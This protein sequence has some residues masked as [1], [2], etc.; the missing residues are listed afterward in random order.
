MHWRR[1]RGRSG[2]Q[3]LVAAAATSGRVPGLS[4]RPTFRGRGR[5]GVDRRGGD[6]DRVRLPRSRCCRRRSSPSVRAGRQRWRARRG[7]AGRRRWTVGWSCGMRRWL[8]LVVLRAAIAACRAG[9]HPTLADGSTVTRCIRRTRIP[10]QCGP[11]ADLAANPITDPYTDRRPGKRPRV[12]AKERSSPRRR[13]L[14]LVA[15]VVSLDSFVPQDQAPKLALIADAASLLAATLAPQSP[16]AP[17]TP[18]GSSGWR[19]ALS[20]GGAAGQGGG[21]KPTGRITRWLA[22]DADLKRLM[23]ASDDATVLAAR[24]WC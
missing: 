19:R 23:V 13:T 22:I 2:G 12:A 1:R 14:P 4:C 16:A 5:A 15:Q 10:R 6:A 9:R 8:V 20:A 3:I 24:T 11:S 7:L 21:P 17:V 18:D